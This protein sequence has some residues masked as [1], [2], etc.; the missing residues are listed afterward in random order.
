MS[1][2]EDALPI[3]AHCD[4][5][6]SVNIEQTQNDRIYGRLFGDWPEIYY[7]HDCKA[8]VG[9]HPGTIIPLGRMADRATRQLRQKVHDAFDPIWKSKLMSRSHAYDWL[10][11]ELGIASDDCH[12]SWLSKDQLQRAVE[13][14]NQHFTANEK[15]I[16]RRKARKNE[17]TAKR[18][19]REQRE[20]ERNSGKDRKRKR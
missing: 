7:C 5:C 20:Y 8:A 15:I 13:I 3:P 1:Q 6:G 4:N 16:E 19:L 18:N 12:I 14:C 10:A 9:C 2:V 11:G 17:R